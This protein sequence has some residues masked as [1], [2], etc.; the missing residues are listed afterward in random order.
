M[1]CETN[2]FW[3]AYKYLAS[4][5]HALHN[6]MHQS[7]LWF[8]SH[9]SGQLAVGFY[10]MFQLTLRHPW[11]CMAFEVFKYDAATSH[12]LSAS[13][14]EFHVSW[15]MTLVHYCVQPPCSAG[16][17]FPCYSAPVVANIFFCYSLYFY[18]TATFINVKMKPVI[19]IERL[20]NKYRFYY[21]IDFPDY[22]SERT[23]RGLLWL[24]VFT[25]VGSVRYKNTVCSRTLYALLVQQTKNLWIHRLYQNLPSES[26]SSRDLI[27][28]GFI[29]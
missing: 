24:Q 11:F 8:C 16:R 22:S 5:V 27:L 21:I 1:L 10:N 26:S 2:E 29:W 28:Q 3:R 13:F 23:E 4:E 25:H 12:A 17:I 15:R 6:R 9:S 19:A 14:T 18:F 7:I 20:C